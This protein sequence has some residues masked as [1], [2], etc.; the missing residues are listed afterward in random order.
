[1]LFI[2]IERFE[3]DDMV[4]IYRRLQEK[5]RQLPEGEEGTFCVTP[6]WTGH[7]TPFLRW[8]SG[9]IVRYIERGDSPG[10]FAELFPMIRHAQR[11]T[12]FF[13]VRGV[14]INHAELEDFMFQNPLVNDFQGVLVT[15]DGGLETLELHIEVKRGADSD[16]VARTVLD[17]VKRSFEITPEIRVL[18]LGSLA[19]AFESSIK[20][21][22]FVDRRS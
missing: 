16:A 17:D 13:K 9:D 12:G 18:E 4:P 14:N 11:T 3:G 7:A 10:Q 22:R 6:L 20:A 1:M 2:V 15:G 8:N 21:P 19:K 5:G